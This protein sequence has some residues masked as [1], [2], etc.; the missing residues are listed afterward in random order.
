[1]M[2][3]SDGDHF[4]R[5]WN[6]DR[7][8][9][10]TSTLTLCSNVSVSKLQRIWDIVTNILIISPVVC[11]KPWKVRSN[12]K[13]RGGV[14]VEKCS[15]KKLWDGFHKNVNVSVLVLL[16]PRHSGPLRGQWMG[17]IISIN[18]IGSKSQL[19][20]SSQTRLEVSNRHN[21]PLPLKSVIL[22]I[23]KQVLGLRWK[24]NWIQ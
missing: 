3:W 19:M 9:L 13:A 12:L 23:M 10:M 2:M 8:V 20:K 17:K 7:E 16:Q 15:K 1:M 14:F 24:P 18:N 11:A 4:R 5:R 21:W 6:A 22:R